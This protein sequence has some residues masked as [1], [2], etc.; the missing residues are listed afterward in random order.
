ME[1]ELQLNLSSNIIEGLTVVGNEEM[2]AVSDEFF[3][4]STKGYENRDDLIRDVRN[5]GVVQGYAL[6]IKRSKPN[7]YVVMGCDRGGCYRTG[8]AVENKKRNSSSRLINCPFKILGRKKEGVWKVE[9]ITLLHNHESSTDMSGHPYCRRFSKEEALQVKQMTRAGIK[10]RQIL[11]SLRQNN[12]GLLAV[13]T[14]MY[15]A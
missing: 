3:S 12:P 13:S 8:I 4:L 2:F 6:V 14:E 11:S 10:P 7:R 9:I 15:M 1:E 5:L